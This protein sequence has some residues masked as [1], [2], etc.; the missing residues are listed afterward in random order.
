M[1]SGVKQLVEDLARTPALVCTVGRDGVVS[2]LFLD[3]TVRKVEFTDLW[4][5]V[6][7][8]GW[9]IH[10]NLDTIA[11]VRFTEAAGHDDSVSVFVSLDDAQGNAVLRFYFPHASQTHR[12]YTAQELSLFEAFKARYEQTFGQED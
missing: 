2:E 9:H 10:A 5:T 11:K 12:T 4:A 3:E 1:I 7:Y 6:E 8:S